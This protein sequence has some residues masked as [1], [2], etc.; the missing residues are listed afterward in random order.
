SDREYVAFM[1][2][3]VRIQHGR[4][5]D[6]RRSRGHKTLSEPLW[7]LVQTTAEEST[8][9]PHAAQ[10]LIPDFGDCLWS[11]EDLRSSHA[12]CLPHPRIG[13]GLAHILRSGP[14]TLPP[15]PAHTLP[16][17]SLKTRPPL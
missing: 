3:V 6:A 4:T 7:H 14:L 5:N 17:V 12:P 2:I 9:V 10:L 16:D 13:G 8:F 15:Q 1:R 11:V